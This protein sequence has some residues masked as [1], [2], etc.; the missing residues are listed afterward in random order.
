M[1]QMDTQQLTDLIRRHAGLIHK[2]AFAYCRDGTDREDV[3]QEVALQLWRSRQRYDE[4]FREST[5]VYRIAINVA[6][7]FYRRE[8]R[9]RER[10][11][12]MDDCA[13]TITAPSSEPSEDVQRLLLCVH[14]L[15]P[16]D[17]AL[18]LLYLDDYDHESI[19]DVLGISVSNVGT[20]LSRIKDKLRLAFEKNARPNSTE[21]PDAT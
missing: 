13:I 7:S 18:V 6:I 4:R 1:F 3:I 8:R 20:K 21:K 11:L 9:H 16:L 2:V 12:P 10:R 14:N 5:W 17:K 15:G 19:A